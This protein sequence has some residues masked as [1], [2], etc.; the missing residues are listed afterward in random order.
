MRSNVF[1]QKVER[2]KQIHALRE[3]GCTYKEIADA[4]GVNTVSVWKYLK[5]KEPVV[6][7]R[8]KLSLERQKIAREMKAA[9]ATYR[10]IGEH[11]GFSAASACELVRDGAGQRRAGV[12]PICNSQSDD[13]IPHH[14][15]YLTDEKMWICRKCHLERIHPDAI[16]RAKAARADDRVKDKTAILDAMGWKEIKV[17]VKPNGRRHIVGIPPN[18]SKPIEAPNPLKDLNAIRCA[19]LKL[20][21]AQ[22]KTWRGWMETICGT[23]GGMLHASVE[24]RAEAFLR[25]I[26]KWENIKP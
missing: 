20:N 24:Q 11:F 26:G 17:E 25:T 16:N 21:E 5:S 10:E 22:E 9:G 6:P 12:C 1:L 13:L 18:E 8:R 2:H 23:Q 14:T 15:N 7:P 19:E 3:Q 4:V